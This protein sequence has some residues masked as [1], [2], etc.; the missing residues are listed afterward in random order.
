MVYDEIVSLVGTLGFPIFVAVYFMATTNK[1]LQTNTAALDKLS[2]TDQLQAVAL[3]KLS[4]AI[5]RL[6]EQQR[7]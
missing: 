2:N 6:C 5:E 3:A 7:K 4:D 1:I